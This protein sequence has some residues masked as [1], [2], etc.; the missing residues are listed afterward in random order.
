MTTHQFRDLLADETAHLPL[1]ERLTVTAFLGHAIAFARQLAG[2]TPP[3]V[4]RQAI[5]LK[6]LTLDGAP[7]QWVRILIAKAALEACAP[8]VAQAA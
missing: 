5:V 4:A 3:A 1:P 6:L 7:P 2:D 8:P